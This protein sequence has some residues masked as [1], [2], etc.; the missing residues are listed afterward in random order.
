MQSLFD[1]IKARKRGFTLVEVI[2]AIAILAVIMAPLG[3]TVAQIY[4]TN[5]LGQNRTLAIRQVQNVGQ[6]I[7]RD[8]LQATDAITLG[9]INGFTLTFTEDLARYGIGSLRV[10]SYSIDGSGNLTR[11]ETIGGVTT[12]FVIASDIVFDPLIVDNTAPTYFRQVGAVFELKVTA[13]VGAGSTAGTETRFY[14][15]EPRADNV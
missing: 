9:G 1:T 13:D 4:R 2:V 15:V 5:Q 11:S 8:A 10:V 14:K 6:Y 3:M 12:S 7:S